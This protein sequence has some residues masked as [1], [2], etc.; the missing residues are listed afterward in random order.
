MKSFIENIGKN[1]RQTDDEQFGCNNDN[2]KC[3]IISDFSVMRLEKDQIA[4]EC[5]K[6]ND[7]KKE[8]AQPLQ[9]D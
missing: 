9:E 2:N 4:P 5:I 6:Q 7:H 8:I 3:C 1:R